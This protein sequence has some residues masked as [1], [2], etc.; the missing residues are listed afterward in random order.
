MESDTVCYYSRRDPDLMR[1]FARL[2]FPEVAF[3]YL[4]RARPRTSGRKAP[5][6][7]GPCWKSSVDSMGPALNSMSHRETKLWVTVENRQE[8]LG[9]DLSYSVNRFRSSTIHRFSEE[10]VDA[11]KDVIRSAISQ[12]DS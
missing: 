7:G 12:R 5:L 9:I 8:G 10:F 3:N 6:Q 2:P 11:L 1:D 4:A